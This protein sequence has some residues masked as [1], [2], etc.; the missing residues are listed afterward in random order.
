MEEDRILKSIRK[1]SELRLYGHILSKR[2]GTKALKQVVNH[3]W[4]PGGSGGRVTQRDYLDLRRHT[5]C[6][7]RLQGHKDFLGFL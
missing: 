2:P 3:D 7:S 5:L 4:H 1:A 6:L